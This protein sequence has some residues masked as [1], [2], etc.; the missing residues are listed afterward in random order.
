MAA[1]KVGNTGSREPRL[2]ELTV[3]A[4]VLVG[5]GLWV[6]PLLIPV[7]G[8]PLFILNAAR[9]AGREVVAI[10]LILISLVY[11]GIA[12]LYVELFVD[13]WASVALPRAR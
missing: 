10:A 12:L 5:L 9:H 1:G 2:V 11:L 3:A 4:I 13:F 6:T 7:L 8:V